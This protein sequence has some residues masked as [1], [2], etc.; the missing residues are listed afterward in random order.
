[1]SRQSSFQSDSPPPDDDLAAEHSPRSDDDVP[2]DRSPVDYGTGCLGKIRRLDAGCCRGN[3]IARVC[4]FILVTE[5]CERLAYYGLT[6][7]LTI[8]FTKE[9]GLKAFFSTCLTSLFSSLNYLTPLLGAWVADGCCGRY[10]TISMF[11]V[12]YLLGL[13]MCII[14]AHP[15]IKSSAIFNIGLFVG[16]AIGAGGIKPNV[17]VFGADQFDEAIPAEVKQ[18]EQFFGFFYW[19]INIGATI[20]Y[21]Y[22]AQLAVNGQPAIGI[23]V[24]YGFFASFIVPGVAMMVGFLLFFAGTPRYKQKKPEGSAFVRFLKIV[25]HASIRSHQGRALLAACTALVTGMC[26]VVT[27][28]FV[29]PSNEALYI[30]HVVLAITGMVLILCGLIGIVIFSRKTEFLR[31]ASVTEGGPYAVID[32]EGAMEVVKLFPYLCFLCIFWACYGQLNTNFLLQGCQMDLRWFGNKYNDEGGSPDWWALGPQ[33]SV[34]FLNL[35]DTVV[36]LAVIPLLQLVLCPVLAWDPLWCCYGKFATRVH[37]MLGSVM[38]CA[39]GKGKG[40]TN[41]NAGAHVRKELRRGRTITMMQKIGCGFIACLL[42]LL[43]A[44]FVEIQRKNAPL[45]VLDPPDLARSNCDDPN[46]ETSTTVMRDLSIWWLSIQF[47][48]IGVAEVLAAVTSYDLFYSEVPP[49]MRSVCQALNLLTTSIGAMVTGGINSMFSD[50]IP[51]DLDQGHLEYVFFFVALITLCTTIGFFLV[52]WGF[53]S[54]M[55]NSNAA[56]GGFGEVLDGEEDGALRAEGS[57]TESLRGRSAT[58]SARQSG[59]GGGGGGGGGGGAEPLGGTMNRRH[60]ASMSERFGE[61]TRTVGRT[62][63]VANGGGSFSPIVTSDRPD[64]GGSKRRGVV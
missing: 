18:K 20:A 40:G 47:T 8:F 9:L 16:V 48:L 35:F 26:V 17:V 22:L 23:P 3:I 15:E 6:G 10:R 34:S 28:Y 42:S 44:A 58:W 45:L 13:A 33:V 5:L 29:D 2:F 52:S 55:S 4:I 21:A 50:W 57:L 61:L 14:G 43:A 12:L 63:A 27:G 31:C 64:L 41:G 54:K 36:I 1:M 25:F 59:S 38:C 53:E 46:D 51:D 11:G 37:A 39:R 24:E 32:I 19:S 49:G 60:T 56:G 7:S 30:A 62:I